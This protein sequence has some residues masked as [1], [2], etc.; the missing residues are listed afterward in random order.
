MPATPKQ[1]PARRAG[2]R[3]MPRVQRERQILAVAGEVFAARGYHAASM[4]DI[5][6]R[7]DLSKPMLYAYFGSKEGLHAAYIDAAG[8]ELLERIRSAASQELG[9][10]ER[11]RAGI[12]AFLAFVDEHR[13]GW[14]V[15]Y[16]EAA[17][18]AGAVAGQ[19]VAL[20]TRVAETIGRLIEASVAGRRREPSPAT[21]D[22]L[23]HACV[24][25]GESLANW[26]LAHREVDRA[27]IAAWLE[28]FI[29]AGLDAALER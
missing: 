19:V 10:D 12:D 5:A 6:E 2:T 3:G 24:G 11:V 14:A 27:M 8:Q 23:G 22:A 29:R 4:D 16:S 15:L 18:S 9:P 1:R 21:L 26:W 28:G 20:R 17:G 13:D 25:A 7:C